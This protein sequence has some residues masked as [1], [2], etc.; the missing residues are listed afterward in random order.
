MGLL[1][2]AGQLDSG[3]GVTGTGGGWLSTEIAQVLLMLPTCCHELQQGF[4]TLAT[5]WSHLGSSE[6]YQCPG[7]PLDQRSQKLWEV[8]HRT[9]IS[10][11][12]RPQGD[13]RGC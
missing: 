3:Q 4:S 10:R 13:V 6:S 8:G 7:C 9:G 2:R 5:C 11:Y 12:Q 1:G